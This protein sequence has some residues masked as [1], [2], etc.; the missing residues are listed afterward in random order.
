VEKAR[1]LDPLSLITNTLQGQFLRF[2]GHDDEAGRSLEKAL[3]LDSNFWVA[4]I[5]LANILI[6]QK[7]YAQ[8][9]MHLTKAREQSGGNTQTISLTAYALALAGERERARG[10]LEDLRRMS[11][12]RY[13]PPYNLALV[14]QG[15]GEREEALDWLE[16]AFDARDVLL[17]FVAVDSKWDA[18]RTNERFVRLL[19]RMK[20][21]N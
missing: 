21:H 3:E 16:K 9:L 7:M 10:L 8:A 14:H 5:N 12:E 6:E 18:L 13:V 1:E 17:T 19:E 2:A 20:L 15:L 4:Q 11:G